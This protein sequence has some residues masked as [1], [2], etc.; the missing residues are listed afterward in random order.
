MD[1][2]GFSAHGFMPI[3]SASWLVAFLQTYLFGNDAQRHNV[4]TSIAATLGGQDLLGSFTDI[5]HFSKGKENLIP[6]CHRFIWAPLSSRPWGETV[7]P[8]GTCGKRL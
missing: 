4:A 6:K 8:C 5:L 2:I 1:I 3:S 7:D